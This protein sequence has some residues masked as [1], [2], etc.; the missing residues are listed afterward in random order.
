MRTIYNILFTIG[1]LLSFPYYFFRLWRRGGWR[2]GFS[3]RF[4]TYSARV[5]QALTNR[6]IVWIHAVSVGEV[7]LATLLVR[8][9]EP[10]LPTIKFVVSTTTTTGMAE[11]RRKLPLIVEKVYYPI[12]R[13]PWVRRAFGILNPEVLILIEAELWPNALWQAR[14]RRVPVIL[15]NARISDRSFPRYRRAGFLFR[16]LFQGLEA[17][18]AQSERD[19][20]RLVQLGCRAEVVHPVGSLKFEPSIAGDTR[21]LDVPKL[22]RQAGMPDNARVLLAGSTHDGE[23]AALA[24]IFASL[25]KKHPDLYLVLVPRHFERARAIGSQLSRRGMRYVYRSEVNFSA[26]PEPGSSECLLVNSTGELRFFYPHAQVVFIGKSLHGVG[27][28]NPIEPAAAGRAIVFGPNMQNFPDIAPRFL[29]ADAAVQVR[30]AAQLE[31][32]LDALL[33][34]PARCE[35]LGRNAQQVVDSN[36]GALDRN[37]AMILDVL[38]DHGIV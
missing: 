18:S 17:V 24:D 13:R 6:R 36:R 9:L 30:N 28:Q 14:R 12:D 38:K 20:D 7:N 3:E 15:A 4:G 29:E 37:V 19:R 1:F 16:D 10:R 11:L 34:D 27:G 23:E 35:I 8:A 2:E 26:E 21:P 25:R 33:N 5:K 31:R 32:A 22:L